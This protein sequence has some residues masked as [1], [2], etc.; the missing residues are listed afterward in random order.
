MALGG[1]IL[2]ALFTACSETYP[3]WQQHASLP[4]PIGFAG[5]AA[6]SIDNSLM[7]LGGARFP[8]LPPW[9]GGFKEYSGSIWILK[10]PNSS[11]EKA[12]IRLP[13]P[14]AYAVSGTWNNTIV[15]AGGETRATSNSPILC[16][17][18]VYAITST[19]QGPRVTDLPRLPMPVSNAS[20]TFVGSQLFVAGGNESPQ[21]PKAL[22]QLLVL[23]VSQ[24]NP[25]W[26]SCDPWPGPARILA[27]TATFGNQ[28]YL[29]GGAE[30]RAGPHGNP[31]RHYLRDAYRRDQYGQ[32]HRLADMPHP[33]AAAASPAPVSNGL[34]WIISGDDG[35]KVSRDP[36]DH[37]GFMPSSLSY[38]IQSNS[39]KIGPVIP[40]PRVTL[41]AIPWHTR[42]WLISGEMKPGVRSPEIWS[43]NPT[44]W[45]HP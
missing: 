30:L 43:A 2:G 41:P 8:K 15:M 38:N 3:G 21:A 17:S 19:A 39:W 6:G 33:T 29:F 12:T 5:M 28:L 24:K 10:S 14:T 25:Q 16:Q 36:A 9:K 37:P 44:V 40:A 32:W 11:W 26:K 45:E 27:T 23:D 1:L 4:D 20:G 35:S 18:R 34:I 7:I 42:W 31:V 13:E 22:K